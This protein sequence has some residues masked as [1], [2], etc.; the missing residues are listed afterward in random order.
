M[1]FVVR[2]ML[3]QFKQTR[4]NSTAPTNKGK[5]KDNI[6]APVPLPWGSIYRVAGSTAAGCASK[7]PNLEHELQQ[8]NQRDKVLSISKQPY[9]KKAWAGCS[10]CF[11]IHAVGEYPTGPV[12]D[13]GVKRVSNTHTPPARQTQLCAGLTKVPGPCARLRCSSWPPG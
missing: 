4:R 1:L 2:C 10:Y 12:H 3:H 7:G 9:L 13:S 5:C 11:H 6:C 8:R